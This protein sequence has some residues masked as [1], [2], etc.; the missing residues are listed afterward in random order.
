MEIPTTPRYDPGASLFE[1]AGRTS[2][3]ILLARI[4]GLQGAYH[5]EDTLF[6]T[7]GFRPCGLWIRIQPTR[8]EALV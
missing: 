6:V 4:F 2:S 1:E 8:N 5:A 3:E 7:Q